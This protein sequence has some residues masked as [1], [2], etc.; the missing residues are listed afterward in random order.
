MTR[1]QD[2]YRALV[3]KYGV[4]EAARRWKGRGAEENPKRK[5]RATRRPR[6]VAKA[7]KAPRKTR[8]KAKAR[9]AATPKRRRGGRR[10]GR[11]RR[12]VKIRARVKPYRRAKYSFR[13]PSGRRYWTRKYFENPAP[14]AVVA[15]PKRRPRKSAPKRKKTRRH[16]RNPNAGGKVNVKALVALPKLSE[17]KAISSKGW[18]G[19]AAFGVGIAIPAVL[20]WQFENWARSSKQGVIKAEWQ[21]DLARVGFKFGVGTVGSYVI[22]AVTKSSELARK[23]QLG[24]Y[25]GVLLDIGGTAIKYLTRKS[26]KVSGMDGVM[27]LPNTP[28]NALLHATGFGQ[29]AEAYEEFKLLGPLSKGHELAGVENSETGELAIVDANTGDMLVEG[30]GKEELDGILEGL[31]GVK[32]TQE[33]DDDDE[34]LGD[35]AED[36]GDDELGEDITVE[37]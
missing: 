25:T 37:S 11:K 4:P 28:K 1:A 35:D 22:G 15:N 14:P 31:S 8:R 17:F 6:K 23:S 29:F 24:V 5:P 26:L 32:V 19:Y 27:T 13:G 36:F 20:G 7:P 18:K 30:L 21:M 33:G 16:K 12:T 9:P 10:K 2:A 34:D 3:R